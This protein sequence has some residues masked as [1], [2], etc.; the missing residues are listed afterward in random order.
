MKKN[1]TPALDRPKM[2]DA[3][4]ATWLLPEEQVFGVSINGDTRAYPERIL[5]WHEMLNDVVGSRP[6]SL[7]YCTLCGAAILYDGRASDQRTYTFGSSGLLYR[8]NKLMFDRQT[9]TL[10][11]QLT[12]EPVMGPLVKK[13]LAPLRVLPLTVTSWREWRVMHPDTKVLSLET[14]YS[15]DYRPG[16]AY[17]KYFASPDLM[18]PVWKKAPPS[19]ET[20]EWVLVV[21][22]GDVRKV[23]PIDDLHRASLVHD[24]VG[25]R[26]VVLLMERGYF[27]E[28]RRFRHEGAELV[29]EKTGERFAIT[30]DALTSKAGTRLS[31][32]PPTDHSGLEPGRSIPALK[33]GTPCLLER[34][35]QGTPQRR[36]CEQPM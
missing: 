34:A 12:G 4:G 7:S 35:A 33:S 21:N 16:A 18:F 10:W 1:G 19:L 8:S 24:R 5:A 27:S 14:G 23:Y 31:R 6:V 15:R 36:E 32:V 30:E 3:A 9:E 17:G 20:K 28:G 13:R 25:D 2:I 29:D 22:T 26:D 11:S